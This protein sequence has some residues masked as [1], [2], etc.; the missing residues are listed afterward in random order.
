M[1]IETHY[2]CFKKINGSKNGKGKKYACFGP[3]EK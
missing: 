2:Q 1:M 3:D